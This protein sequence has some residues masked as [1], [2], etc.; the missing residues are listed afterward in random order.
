MLYWTCRAADM[1][2]FSALTFSSHPAKPHLQSMQ[3]RHQPWQLHSLKAQLGSGKWKLC[4]IS[5]MSFCFYTLKK[6]KKDFDSWTDKKNVGLVLLVFMC[7]GQDVCSLKTQTELTNLSSSNSAGLSVLLSWLCHRE[8]HRSF[9]DFIPV[10][11]SLHNNTHACQPAYTWARCLCIRCAWPET[12]TRL[13]GGYIAKA[14]GELVIQKW[15]KK[16]SQNFP[17]VTWLI[18]IHYDK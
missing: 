7:T 18:D 9:T 3:R 2:S 16:C 5:K 15:Q 13:V 14:I 6:K 17:L 4:S 11:V 12:C 1:Q 10:T 8:K